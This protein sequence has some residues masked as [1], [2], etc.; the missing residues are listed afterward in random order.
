MQRLRV[1]DSSSTDR[2]ITDYLQSSLCVPAGGTAES[3]DC[4][5]A[6]CPAA[7]QANDRSEDFCCRESTR[8]EGEC[9][10]GGGRGGRGC[11]RL[12]DHLARLSAIDQFAATELHRTFVLKMSDQS[13]RVA[14]ELT[15]EYVGTQ[16]LQDRVK[17]ACMSCVPDITPCMVLSGFA[18]GGPPLG[19]SETQVLSPL[20][21]RSQTVP[22][23]IDT[24][25]PAM[26]SR[27]SSRQQQDL[28]V[29]ADGRFL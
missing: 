10:G 12:F 23:H 14:C 17:L 27:I 11:L 28:Q 26:T 1:Y 29:A 21:L 2:M 3:A 22:K 13:D 8:E 20:L 9:A 15:D 18:D 5:G 4:R 24:E 6:S 25:P 7:A 19:L 16:E